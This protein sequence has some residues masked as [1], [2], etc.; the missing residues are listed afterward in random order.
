MKR[1]PED[2]ITNKMLIHSSFQGKWEKVRRIAVRK[3][4]L[5]IGSP[6]TVKP[7]LKSPSMTLFLHARCPQIHAFEAATP[8]HVWSHTWQSH[9]P[10]SNV[11]K[12]Y[13]FD[14]TKPVNDATFMSEVT[15]FI[16]SKASKAFSENTVTKNVQKCFKDSYI[17]M[18]WYKHQGN[19]SLCL[20]CRCQAKLR[21][22]VRITLFNRLR[23]RLHRFRFQAYKS[24]FSFPVNSAHFKSIGSASEKEGVHKYF[25]TCFK[26]VWKYL[27]SPNKLFCRDATSTH[28]YSNGPWANMKGKNIWAVF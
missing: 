20:L 11:W 6:A 3:F 23:K 21:H 1:A 26:H 22:I 2:S 9:F 7:A 5:R 8:G 12:I 24:S 10:L 13:H 18:N 17:I 28:H 14:C 4:N 27:C 19:L 15:G 16:V 25:Q